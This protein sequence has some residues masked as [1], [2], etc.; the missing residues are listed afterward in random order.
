MAIVTGAGTG[1]GRAVALALGEAGWRVACLGRRADLLENTGAPLGDRA[2][3]VP[4]DVTRPEAVD[5]AFD[6]VAARWGRIDL[7]FNN[8]GRGFPAP[9][10]SRLNH[11][12]LVNR[13]ANPRLLQLFL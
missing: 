11:G 10:G 6:R 1:I 7:L 3:A 9:D 5:A 13:S 2:L 8:A 12:G 4:C